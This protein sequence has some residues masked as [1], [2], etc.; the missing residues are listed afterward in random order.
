MQDLGMKCV[1]GKFVPWLLLPE[2]KEQGTAVANNL[3]QTTTS[4]PG[5]LKKVITGDESWV[6]GYSYDP[7][8]K[9]QLSQ[10]KLPILHT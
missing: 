6:Y 10:W 8:M 5:F 4:E 7:E 9:A 2:Q 3:I 1:M